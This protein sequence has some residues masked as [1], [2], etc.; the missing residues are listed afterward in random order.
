MAS[1]CLWILLLSMGIL[2]QGVLRWGILSVF[3]KPMPVRYNAAV[4]PRFFTTNSSMNLPYLPLDSLAASLGEN[5]TFETDGSLCFTTRNHSNCLSLKQ[6]MYGWFSR[7]RKSGEFSQSFR[8]NKTYTYAAVSQMVLWINGTFVK[9]PIK[10]INYSN[11]F[12][13]YRPRQPKY[14]P[15]CMGDYEGEQ[16][17]WTDCQS[18]ATT[19]ADEG[20]KFSLSPDMEEIS[21]SVYRRVAEGGEFQQDVGRNPFH[22]WLLCG[23][24]GSCSDLSPF[25]VLQGGGIGMSNS[26]CTYESTSPTLDGKTVYQVNKTTYNI[27]CQRVAPAPGQYPPTPVCV[28][29]PFLFILS[30]NS[31][32]SCSNDT[33]FLSQCWNITVHSNALVARIPRWVPVPVDS[34]DSMTL[35]REK[36]DFGVTAAIVALISLAAVAATAA[37]IALDTSVKAAAE[38]NN[39]A[40]S[41]AT[42]LD[43]QSSLDGKMKGGIMVLNQRRVKNLQPKEHISYG[44]MRGTLTG[45]SRCGSHRGTGF[46]IPSAL[47]SVAAALAELPERPPA[48][49]SPGNNCE[50]RGDDTECQALHISP[51][52]SARGLPGGGSHDV[53]HPSAKAHTVKAPPEGAAPDTLTRGSDASRFQKRSTA[54]AAA[55][56]TPGVWGAVLVVGPVLRE[57]FKDTVVPRVCCLVALTICSSSAVLQPSSVPAAL[58][59]LF[60]GKCSRP[61]LHRGHPGQEPAAGAGKEC[62]LLLTLH[63]SW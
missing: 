62:S 43:R 40:D 33:C 45:S 36:C 2:T 9:P 46:C 37:A 29:P 59:S 57:S 12:F 41:V 25:I 60:P 24:N 14:A 28:Y 49:T 11:I 3:P 23:V 39:L 20:H 22:K 6:H 61:G 44:D 5:R 18:H 21:G 1:L 26:S 19:W 30:N 32:D 4:F 48:T 34:P 51:H 55:G 54:A 38:L 50:T 56:S 7:D 17:P 63:D 27:S 42:A 16:W 53:P 13:P 58:A 31:F 47:L 15:H 8:E 35:F 10:Q 52:R